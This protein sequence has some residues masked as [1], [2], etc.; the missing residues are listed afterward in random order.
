VSYSYLIIVATFQSDSIITF[1]VI[2]KSLM[3]RV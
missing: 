3:P 1:E 2:K